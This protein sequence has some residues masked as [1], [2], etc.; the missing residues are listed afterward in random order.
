MSI[1]LMSSGKEYE[2]GQVGIF[3]PHAQ[4]VK[5]LGPGEVGFLM[6][7]IKEVREARIGDT[8]TEA[9]RPTGPLCCRALRRRNPW[10][11]AVC[12]R[13]NRNTTRCCAMRSEN[14]V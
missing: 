14:S 11:L 4:A 9:Q 3:A 13:S 8:I 6:A 1:R 10:S 12:I 5:A 2:V 7:G